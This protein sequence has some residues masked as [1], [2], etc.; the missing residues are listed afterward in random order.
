MDELSQIKRLTR[1]FSPPSPQNP[2]AEVAVIYDERSID[3]LRGG[4]AKLHATWTTLQK[5]ELNA[6]GVP[7]RIYYA[8]DMR[9]GK[10]PAAKLYIFLNQLNL[11]NAMVHAI[12][13][14]KKKNAVLVFL[15]GTGFVQADS[16]L[17]NIIK[18]LDMKITK[19]DKQDHLSC[20]IAESHS[21]LEKFDPKTEGL[22]Q[23]EQ[24]G[25]AVI[26]SEATNLAKYPDTEQVGFAVRSFPNYKTIFIGTYMLTQ[27]MIHRLA[28]F[29][30]A[31]CLT[32]P[33][34]VAVAADEFI[35]LHPLKDDRITITLKNSA[36]LH[37]I[38]P[39]EIKTE[40]RKV[41]DLYLRS[42]HTYLFELK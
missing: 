35:M 29:S 19:S 6:S 14:I 2:I 34:T 8:D 30:R 33:G 4:L 27:R 38:Q 12:T 15:Q 23:N 39:D 22:E 24:A 25:L 20:K 5:R 26:D 1:E 18:T 7:Y 40:S 3:Y 21:L 42:G 37:A 36:R 16:S 13:N 11:D 32:S 9:K 28:R 31:W 10:I 17:Q 41:H